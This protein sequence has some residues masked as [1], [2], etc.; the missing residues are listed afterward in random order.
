VRLAVVGNLH[1]QPIGT[2]T[3][4]TSSTV[5]A[6]S[7][8]STTLPPGS[9]FYVHT[10]PSLCRTTA[11]ATV[12]AVDPDGVA[13]VHLRW[14][15]GPGGTS[16]QQPMVRQGTTNRWQLAL[17]FPQQAVPDQFRQ[18]TFAV[19]VTDGRGVASTLATSPVS[20][21]RVYRGNQP[22]AQ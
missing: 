13:S 10:A 4:S 18:P 11:E 6:S 8:T 15:T 21:F 20:E 12:D 14:D 1:G 2:S 19:I 5:P 3:T 16:G 9:F 7:T 17:Q 22:C